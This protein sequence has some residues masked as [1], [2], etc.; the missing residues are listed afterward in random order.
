V[1]IQLESPSGTVALVNELHQPEEHVHRIS[2]AIAQRIGARKFDMWFAHAGLHL[3]GERLTVA[4][5]SPFAAKWID[6]HFADALKSITE[7]ILGR[8]IAIDVHVATCFPSRSDQAPRRRGSSVPHNGTAP[9]GSNGR[10]NTPRELQPDQHGTQ[11]SLDVPASTQ[12][13]GPRP[14]AT[15]INVQVA[16]DDFIIGECNKLAF[17]TACRLAEDADA[18]CISPL[19]IHGDC[20]VG[21]TH[22]L[23]GVCQRFIQTTGRTHPGPLRDG[24]TIYE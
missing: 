5:D 6:S 19:F 3:N 11:P 7:Q 16:L 17:S 2:Q 13:I 15:H 12:Q 14:S 22:L 8:T 20:G 4:A 24:R 21:K 10:V 9:H 18:R 23:Q 1:P